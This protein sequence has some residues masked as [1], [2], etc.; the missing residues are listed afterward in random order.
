MPRKTQ[1]SAIRSDQVTYKRGSGWI[2]NTHTV[3][4]K[5][6]VHQSLAHLE[7]SKESEC[8][9][10]SGAE[11]NQILYETKKIIGMIP[12]SVLVWGVL[13]AMHLPCSKVNVRTEWLLSPVPLQ[14][15]LTERG[16]ACFEESASFIMYRSP[17]PKLT[18]GNIL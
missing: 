15:G 9:Q 14:K 12:P 11:V 4:L 13:S 10:E 8:S 16:A 7:N 6:S 18:S 1:P 5:V 17:A 2:P 3:F